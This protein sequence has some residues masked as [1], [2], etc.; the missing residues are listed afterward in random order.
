MVPSVCLYTNK[1][2]LLYPERVKFEPHCNVL[3]Y[4][5]R[6]R[7]FNAKVCVSLVNLDIMVCLKIDIMKVERHKRHCKY[8]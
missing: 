1:S 5:I 3:Y 2:A 6:I 8:V 7:E 4:A